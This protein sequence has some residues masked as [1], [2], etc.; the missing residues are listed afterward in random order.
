LETR[1]KYRAAIDGL[2]RRETGENSGDGAEKRYLAMHRGR[3]EKT[4]GLCK[5]WLPGPA[6]DVLDIGR[7]PLTGMLAE[8]YDRVSTLGFPLAGG[9]EPYP[10]SGKDGRPVPHIP[11]DLTR[12]RFVDE[13]PDQEGR[14]DLIV[15]CETIEHMHVAPEFT[16]MLF[17]YLLKDSGRLLVTTP[18]GVR[19]GHR[20]RFMLGRNPFERIRFIAE[21]PGH[22]R[23]YTRAELRDMGVDAGLTCLSSEVVNMYSRWWNGIF[24]SG[25][26]RFLGDNLVAVYAKAGAR[27]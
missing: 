2:M 5:R 23:E 17:A 22:F 18:N 8:H 7:S 1:E 11:F 6:A 14:F 26:L 19:I 25:P 21:N 4:L 24:S 3:F 9:G 16:Y 13:W 12:C 20:I 15:Y 10:I 27:A